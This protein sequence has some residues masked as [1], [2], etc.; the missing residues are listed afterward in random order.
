[1]HHVTEVR[2]WK[3]GGKSEC[4]LNTKNLRVILGV[5]LDVEQLMETCSAVWGKRVGSQVA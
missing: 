4:T 5:K 2:C 1:M 3:E